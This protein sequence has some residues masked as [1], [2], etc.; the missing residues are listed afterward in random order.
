MGKAEIVFGVRHGGPGGNK[1]LAGVIRQARLYDRALSADEIAAS[2]GNQ[3]FVA[4]TE[5]LAHLGLAERKLRAE[6]KSQQAKLGGQLAAIQQRSSSVK[7]YAA[8]SV[9]PAHPPPAPRSGRPPA[10]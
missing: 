5:L 2:A 4:E 6:L 1:M 10:P 7:V 9:Q 8:L 3:D